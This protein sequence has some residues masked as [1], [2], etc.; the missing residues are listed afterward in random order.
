M[1]E[2]SGDVMINGKQ[3]HER[4]K[5]EKR[6]DGWAFIVTSLGY[7]LL[8]NVP[9]CCCFNPQQLQLAACSLVAITLPVGL[10]LHRGTA[11]PD[12]SHK[13]AR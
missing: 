13:G 7:C 4:N 8:I 9:T 6:T 2:E 1:G 3:R 11:P 10:H 5:G 12:N